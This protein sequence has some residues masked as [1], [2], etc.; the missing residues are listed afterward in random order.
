MLR[1]SG[2]EWDLRSMQPYEVY[3]RVDFDVP[4]GTNGDSYDRYLV[5]IAEM[6]ESNRIIRQCVNWLR[7]NPGPVIVENHKVAPPRRERMKTGME[8]LIHHF[9][10]F[11]EGMHVPEGEA[12]AAIEHPTGEFGIYMVSAEI[13]RASCRERVWQYG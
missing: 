10:L 12:Y 4:V 13:G 1:G 2:V 11:T 7:N 3:D 9:K 5:R 8:D 6:R